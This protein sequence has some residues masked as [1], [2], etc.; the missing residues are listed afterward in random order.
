MIKTTLQ[1][2]NT[3]IW[4]QCIYWSSVSN[5]ILSQ[6]NTA[7]CFIFLSLLK[8]GFWADCKT[9]R[10]ALLCSPARGWLRNRRPVIASKLHAS[11][12]CGWYIHN[13]Q[14]AGMSSI[15]DDCWAY[16]AI[17]SSLGRLMSLFISYSTVSSHGNLLELH[18]FET[19][20]FCQ[21]WLKLANSFKSYE[22]EDENW[23]AGSASVEFISLQN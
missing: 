14:L 1:T 23:Q 5:E 4:L 22:G 13:D 7:P 6:Q 10:Q 18:I 16:T 17:F 3:F 20:S 9:H 21:I 2:F 19:R 12:L 11:G 15:I 8:S